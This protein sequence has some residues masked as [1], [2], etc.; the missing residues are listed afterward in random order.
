MIIDYTH[1]YIWRRYYGQ[2]EKQKELST[3]IK[4]NGWCIIYES[5]SISCHLHHTIDF[6]WAN[7]NNSLLQSEIGPHHFYCGPQPYGGWKNSCTSWYMVYPLIISLFT[8][9]HSYLAVA[10]WCRISSI[11][12]ITWNVWPFGDDS[13]ALT[14]IPVTRLRGL[15]WSTAKV[16]AEHH[17]ISRMET[18]RNPNHQPLY[19]MFGDMFPRR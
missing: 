16:I 11:H 5:W 2:L 8:I 15:G 6:F 14:M 3:I 10:N 13:P 4:L 19:T 17:V 9:F 1:I 12:S 18:K 7:Y